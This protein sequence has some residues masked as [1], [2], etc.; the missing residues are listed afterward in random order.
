MDF[1]PDSIAAGAVRESDMQYA[2]VTAQLTSNGA[3]INGETI[4]LYYKV[5]LSGSWTA[6]YGDTTDSQGEISKDFY[7]DKYGIPA[8]TTVYFKAVFS[9]S[10]SYGASNA[11]SAN[12]LI[13]TQWLPPASS[14]A[15]NFSPETIAAGAVKS[16]DMEYA[17]V[18]AQLTLNGNPLYSR[19][20]NLYYKV[21]S[22]DWQLFFSAL[23]ESNGFI[24]RD[25][26]PDTFGIAGGTVV[27][28]KATYTGT[29]IVGGSEAQT[30]TGLIVT[31][32][33]P[34]ASSLSINF[35]PGTIISGYAASS[36]WQHATI[37][38][39]LTL[40][41]SPLYDRSVSVYYKVGSTGNWQLLAN[42]DTNNEGKITADFCP[43]SLGIGGNT[44][45]FFKATYS[46]TNIVG[47]S[48]AQTTTGLILTSRI[49]VTP[50]YPL[51]ILLALIANF[52]ALA[53]FSKTK[54]HFKHE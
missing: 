6:F 10:S 26:Y 46:G 27:Y 51:G 29:N 53:I 36:D 54:R 16:S 35:S 19:T 42:M 13:L 33:M 9:G 21:G 44:V 3:P 45:I 30:T 20:V 5:D 17:T 50:E 32:W 47:A 48:E 28:F 14:L 25:F 31:Q 23:T 39:Q 40:G 2:T 22:G 37:V 41:D 11:E 49:F 43:D 1:S 8:G 18:T 38:A 34:P 24:S 4:R 12:G 52:A 7:P 15:V